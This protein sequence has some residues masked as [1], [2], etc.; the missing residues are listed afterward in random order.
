MARY[1]IRVS[2][3]EQ[4]GSRLPRPLPGSGRR[5]IFCSPACRQKAYRVRG[6][7]A[8]GTTGAQRRRNA[9]HATTGT[10]QASRD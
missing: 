4:C 5:M 6:G 1:V 7:Q 9:R 2:T 8:S 10:D 3:C